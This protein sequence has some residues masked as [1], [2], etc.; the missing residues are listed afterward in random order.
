MTHTH[1]KLATAVTLGLAA[2]WA[3]GVTWA[4]SA[5]DPAPH[6][7]RDTDTLAWATQLQACQQRQF[8]GPPL[9]YWLPEASRLRRLIDE[10]EA[11]EARALAAWPATP[12]ARAGALGASQPTPHR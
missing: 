3:S 11:R 7:T 5:G 8:A 9:S 4:E 12:A 2:S 1:R 10:R 6:G